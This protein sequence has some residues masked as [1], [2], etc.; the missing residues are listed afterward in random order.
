M[1]E[2]SYEVALWAVNVRVRVGDGG[3][4]TAGRRGAAASVEVERFRMGLG[5]DMSSRAARGRG[6]GLANE[7]HGATQ[8]KVKGMK[9]GTA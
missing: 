6:R 8:S 3:K 7:G 1:G 2:R 5:V 4:W 9:R